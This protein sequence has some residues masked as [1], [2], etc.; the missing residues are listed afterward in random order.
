MAIDPVLRRLRHFCNCL[1]SSF[2]LRRHTTISAPLRQQESPVL[3]LIYSR[4]KGVSGRE[5]SLQGKGRVG[6]RGRDI[7]LQ[8]NGEPRLNIQVI[9]T[10]GSQGLH[11]L[12][13]G[14]AD[15]AGRSVNGIALFPM[16]QG[17]ETAVSY[18]T[19]A[20]PLTAV[21]GSRHGSYLLL[22]TY[23]AGCL[24]ESVYP[25]T[26]RAPRVRHVSQSIHPC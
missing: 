7:T 18:T 8:G 21:V 10:L 1:P 5:I 17:S 23:Q 6:M 3:Q 15:Y 14:E 2:P 9:S 12:Q 20:S 22:C 26:L 13:T 16:H 4:R 11:L 24:N 25:S 19:Q